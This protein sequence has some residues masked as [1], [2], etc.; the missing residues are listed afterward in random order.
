[1]NVTPPSTSASTQQIPPQTKIILENGV[2]KTVSPVKDTFTWAKIARALLWISGLGTVAMCFERIRIPVD[3]WCNENKVPIIDLIRSKQLKGQSQQDL[4]L[5]NPKHTPILVAEAL[6][7]SDLGKI[8]DPEALSAA[9]CNILS[10]AEYYTN[11]MK[12]VGKRAFEAVKNIKE[13]LE[14]SQLES[15]EKLNDKQSKITLKRK[16]YELEDTEAEA[17]ALKKFEDNA[18]LPHSNTFYQL[19]GKYRKLKQKVDGLRSKIKMLKQKTQKLQ[20]ALGKLQNEIDLNC[21]QNFKEG[22][23]TPLYHL[24]MDLNYILKNGIVYKD[25][26]DK[27][28]L[29]PGIKALFA[30][31][32]KSTDKNEYAQ[33]ILSELKQLDE[34][35]RAEK[36]HPLL[37]DQQA[38]DEVRTWIQE[39]QEFDFDATTRAQAKA[40]LESTNYPTLPLK[41]MEPYDYSHLSIH[42]KTASPEQPNQPFSLN[43]PKSELPLGILDAQEYLEKVK[44]RRPLEYEKLPYEELH[45]MA[46]NLLITF[47]NDIE[48]YNLT[49]QMALHLFNELRAVL[50]DKNPEHYKPLRGSEKSKHEKIIDDLDFEYETLFRALFLNK[51]PGCV[52][53]LEL[54]DREAAINLLVEIMIA[55]PSTQSFVKGV[56]ELTKNCKIH[57]HP[58]VQKGVL[59]Q[60][61]REIAEAS[62]RFQKIQSKPK[63][64]SKKTTQTKMQSKGKARTKKKSKPPSKKPFQNRVQNTD[65]SAAF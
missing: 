31:L 34:V 15:L 55:S 45:R 8:A 5:R 32:P 12:P 44:N 56:E 37:R 33:K 48:E 52:Y 30:S 28:T 63:T 4:N 1:M 9:A 64:K 20:E 46:S 27:W 43:V 6:L 39:N 13:K 14:K 35:D 59:E 29:L 17:L 18:N 60:L 53:L 58:G 51:K 54:D 62:I 19:V 21:L 23:P 25:K 7:N 49:G 24:G 61:D 10:H 11:N 50:N 26:E 38:R 22:K 16:E 41:K 2:L 3:K 57:L 65:G 47:R 42:K 36:S 40:E